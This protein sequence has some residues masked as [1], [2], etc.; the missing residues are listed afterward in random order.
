MAQF[1]F[2]RLVLLDRHRLA[3]D[4]ASAK[5]AD[6]GRVLAAQK[7]F[8]QRRF[9]LALARD[10]VNEAFLRPVIQRHMTRVVPSAENADLAHPLRADAAGGQVDHATVGET[11]ARVGDVL[12]LAQYRKADGIDTDYRRADETQ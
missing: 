4:F 3:H 12:S 9:L 7:L 5:F 11:Q 10:A 1:Q 2:E 8:Q 6:D